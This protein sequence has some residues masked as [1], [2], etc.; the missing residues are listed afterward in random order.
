MDEAIFNDPINPLT[1]ELPTGRNWSGF[2]T[3]SCAENLVLED[4]EQAILA[5]LIEQVAPFRTKEGERFLDQFYTDL[6]NSTKQATFEHAYRFDNSVGEVAYIDNI[7]A[8]EER[9]R[10]VDYKICLSIINQVLQKR[11]PYTEPRLI[12]KEVYNDL[13]TEMADDEVN[14][15]DTSRYGSPRFFLNLLRRHACLGAFTHPK[16]GGNSA[17]VG[18][19]YLESRYRNP[20]GSTLFDWRRAIESSLGT[21]A[22]YLG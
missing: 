17:G 3:D 20:D 7:L 5:R 15:W 13:Y 12:S 19:S 21:N 6:D 16:Y 11:N 9:H 18:W 14:G 2:F 8:R 4:W 1:V 10:I 22:D